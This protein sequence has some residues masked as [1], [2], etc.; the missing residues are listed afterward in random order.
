MKTRR[1][2]LPLLALLILSVGIVGCGTQVG[3]GQRGVFYSKFG[4]GTEMGKIYPEGFTWHLPWNS[5]FLYKIQLQENEEH[6]TVLSS[7]GATITIDVSILYHPIPTKI[8]SLQITIGPDYYRVSVAPSIRGIAR[9]VAGK[10]KPEEIY[11]TK[12][13]EL[14][15]SILQLLQDAMSDK[16]ITIENVVVRDVT[17]PAKIS[18]AINLKLTMDQEAQRKRFELEKEKIE[19]ER[20]RIE[21]QGIADYQ[22]II[23]QGVTPAILKWKGIEATQKLAESPNTK[24]IMVGNDANGL[25]VILNSDK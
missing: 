5:M 2:L 1:Q 25:P 9:E 22:K 10:Y 16:F 3:S 4:S 11:S 15:Q 18:D 20:K 7:D 8:D 13:A 21:A 6:L 17:I 19:A 14:N 23:A 12:R 24:I